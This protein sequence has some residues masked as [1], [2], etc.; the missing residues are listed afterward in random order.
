MEIC[1]SQAL[2]LPAS[3]VQCDTSSSKAACEIPATCLSLSE[4]TCLKA[5]LTSSAIITS[6]GLD[7]AFHLPP[8]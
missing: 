4:C 6:S 8:T 1:K 7:L 2:D 5:A 3:T